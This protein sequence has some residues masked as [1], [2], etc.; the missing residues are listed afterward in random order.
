[1]VDG[2]VQ[3]TTNS[4][5]FDFAAP[6]EG[7]FLLDLS[8]NFRR[9]NLSGGI[10]VQNLLNTRYR[11]YLNEMRYFANESGRNLLFTLKYTLKTNAKND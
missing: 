11:D 8:W 1:L 10:S 3:L 6:T 4:E 7:Y 9:E 5:I 2:A